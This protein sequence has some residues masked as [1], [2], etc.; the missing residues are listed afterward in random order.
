[1]SAGGTEPREITPG[2]GMSFS[3][4]LEICKKFLEL[5]EQDESVI[6]IDPERDYANKNKESW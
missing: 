6:V 5:S 2:S 4:K 3:A 1:M